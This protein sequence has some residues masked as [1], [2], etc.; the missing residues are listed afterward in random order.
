MP[1][2]ADELRY[3]SVTRITGASELCALDVRP[4]A[5]L[6][7]AA[8]ESVSIFTQMIT[9]TYS[10]ASGT[11]TAIFTGFS[12]NNPCGLLIGNHSDSLDVFINTDTTGTSGLL[13]PPRTTIYLA[14]VGT[15]TIYAYC[16]TSTMLSVTQIGV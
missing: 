2:T 9:S 14:Y 15:Q 6:N 11:W 12:V 8:V 13:V 7:R 4:V 5:G 1:T 10:L 3:S 16:S